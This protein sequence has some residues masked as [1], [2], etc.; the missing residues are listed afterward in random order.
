MDALTREKVK[1]RMVVCCVKINVALPF[2]HDPVEF[3]RL[4]VRLT[5]DCTVWGGRHTHILFQVSYKGG[6]H[7]LQRD[8]LR[9]KAVF[10]L[11]L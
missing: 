2:S 10:H 6:I 9:H 5:N 3:V 4:G 1:M 8:F 7:F 11:I